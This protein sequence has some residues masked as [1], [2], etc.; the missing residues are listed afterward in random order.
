MAGINT[1]PQR[2]SERGYPQM[3]RCGLSRVME[4]GHFGRWASTGDLFWS[5]PLAVLPCIN[6]VRRPYDVPKNQ[7]DSEE[8][9]TGAAMLQGSFGKGAQPS[10]SKKGLRI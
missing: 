5:A 10:R 7:G 9:R 6:V 3:Q 2:R 4:T 1:S 8:G